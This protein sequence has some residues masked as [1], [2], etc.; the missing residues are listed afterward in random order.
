M[1]VSKRQ[2][3]PKSFESIL[4]HHP[5]D[6]EARE[7][8]LKWYRAPGHEDRLK[9][10]TR[11]M[12]YYHPGNMYVYFA[13][14][15]LFY[16]QP[17]YRLEII[18]LLEEQIKKGQTNAG[19]YWNLA[20]IYR[21]AGLPP[22]LGA[23]GRVSDF[24]TYMELPRT[25]SLPTVPDHA[26]LEKA[27]LYLKAA[28]D[29]T[30]ANTLDGGLYAEQLGDLLIRLGRAREG[31]GFYQI[32][33]PWVGQLEK[34]WFLLKYGRAL[35][36]IGSIRAAEQVLA[37]VRH[38]DKGGLTGGPSDA[39][40]AAETE[41]GL[42]AV[43]EGRLEDAGRHLLGSVDVERSG[44]TAPTVVPLVLA[45]KLLDMG[46]ARDVAAFCEGALKRLAPV[47]KEV[48]ELLKKAQERSD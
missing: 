17:E 34:P 32:A 45:E 23:N 6:E 30:G 43:Q 4:T 38:C 33:A 44:E 22:K 19:I 1:Q 31:V 25:T 18:G 8:A 21:H 42:I 15:R 47:Q 13:N 26:A 20:M 39:T 46:R 48:R 11:Q 24:L 28:I 36:A 27:V 40:T 12:I 2:G 16:L 29:V 14:V 7:T 10:H 9:Y 3:E 5:E 35:R 37:D 41:L